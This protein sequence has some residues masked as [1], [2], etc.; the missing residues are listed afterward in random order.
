MRLLLLAASG[1]GTG[2]PE[3]R[4]CV[5]SADVFEMED[6]ARGDRPDG[7]D[8]RLLAPGAATIVTPHIGSAVVGDRRRIERDAALSI[9]DY[10]EGGRPRGAINDPVTAP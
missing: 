5:Y 8:P 2:T 6:W 4:A 7:I 10:L 1:S 3:N 9:L